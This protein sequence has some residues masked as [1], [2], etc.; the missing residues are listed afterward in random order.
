MVMTFRG[1]DDI[2]LTGFNHCNQILD[3]TFQ[4]RP[5][6]FLADGKTPLKPYVAVE[7]VQAFGVALRFVCFDV[8]LSVPAGAYGA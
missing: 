1:C 6:G 2:E 7:F 5:R 8:E 3:L 4:F